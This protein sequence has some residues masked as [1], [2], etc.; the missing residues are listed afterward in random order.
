MLLL[1]EEEEEGGS[2]SC[3]TWSSDGCL[4]VQVRPSQPAA[5][6]VIVT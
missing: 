5:T 3:V 2:W 4:T 1:E 6:I